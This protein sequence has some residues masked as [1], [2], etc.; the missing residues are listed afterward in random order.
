MRNLDATNEW[1]AACIFPSEARRRPLTPEQPGLPRLTFHVS[2]SGFTL[3]E[4]MA[5]ILI[6]VL[7]VGVGMPSF[8]RVYRGEILR[9]ETSK[10]RG[11]IQH[12]RYQAIVRQHTMTLN[13]DFSQQ[14]YWIE[15]P[16]TVATNFVQQ[17]LDLST[18]ALA[19][20]DGTF[21]DFSSPTNDLSTNAV[22]LALPDTTHHDMIS[23]VRLVQLEALDGTVSASGVA[24]ILFYPNGA[25][26]GGDILLAG[27][28]ND[29]AGIEVDPLTSLSKLLLNAQA[30]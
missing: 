26:Q 8:L 4:T 23:P 19:F 11:T 1:Q 9:S 29:Q 27:A 20:T 17:V 14:A 13:L 30:R 5:V 15:M 28:G 16:D 24:S 3:I 6:I 2:R 21:P 10:L 12:A 25:C 18:N 7:A 22:I